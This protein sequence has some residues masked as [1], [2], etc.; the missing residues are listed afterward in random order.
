MWANLK[1]WWKRVRGKQLVVAIP[2]SEELYLLYKHVADRDGLD[3]ETWARR[4]L[5]HAVPKTE[6]KRLE[7]GALYAAGLDQA[8]A[9]LDVDEREVNL[10]NHPE[11]RRLLPVVTG[12]PCGNLL[13]EYPPGYTAR[14]CQ[15]LC[16][17]NAPG[18]KGR[19]CQWA[20]AVA[21]D[22]SAFEPRLRDVRPGA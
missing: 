19:V 1:R 2:V 20:S 5:N 4:A 16:A 10:R 9:Q 8:H 11:P 21:D 7:Q 3:V 15:G 6:I 12:H 14:D 18:F 22:C 13:L 17:S